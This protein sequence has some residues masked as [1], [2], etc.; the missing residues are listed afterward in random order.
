MNKTM[1]R[2]LADKYRR[3][4]SVENALAVKYFRLGALDQAIE[5]TEQSEFFRSLLLSYRR[6]AL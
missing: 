1:A 2:R 6:K 5:A 3:R 4:M